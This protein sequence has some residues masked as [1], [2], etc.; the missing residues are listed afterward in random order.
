MSALHSPYINAINRA[1][2]Q[3]RKDIV[4]D[5]FDGCAHIIIAVDN[6]G[7]QPDTT[8]RMEGNHEQLI[9]ALVRALDV[10]RF[11]QLVE[12]AVFSRFFLSH[13]EYDR[14]EF[15]RYLRCEYGTSAQDLIL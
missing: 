14:R 15:M 5:C 1:N 11:R 6:T 2:S 12:T 8:L 13:E 7:K 4:N 10:A 9:D 3:L